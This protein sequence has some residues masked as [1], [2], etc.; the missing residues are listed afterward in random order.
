MFGKRFPSFYTA[1]RCECQAY[2]P[3]R[4]DPDIMLTYTLD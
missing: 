4:V 3:Q 1:R 2:A